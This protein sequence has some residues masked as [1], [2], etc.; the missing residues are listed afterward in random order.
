MRTEVLGYLSR[1]LRTPVNLV[2]FE[3]PGYSFSNLPTG[4][5]LIN[6]A[7]E[8]AY[9]QVCQAVPEDRVV[10]YG[11]SLGTGVMCRLAASHSPAGLILQS[12]YTSLASTA[13]P[14]SCA[15]LLPCCDMFESYGCAPLVKCPVQIIHGADD[16]IIPPR[17]SRELQKLFPNARP[18]VFVD[19][20]GHNNLLWALQD[21]PAGDRWVG[22][23][24]SFLASL[25]SAPAPSL[26]SFP[27]RRLSA[28]GAA[29]AD[30]S[31]VRDDGREPSGA[32]ASA[33]DGGEM[34]GTAQGFETPSGS[35]SG[36][37]SPFQTPAGERDGAGVT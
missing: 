14:T 17:C 19:G 4:E 2:A 13:V 6:A 36:S 16:S 35:G 37:R 30:A 20:A 8:A 15:R 18:A 34:L 5:A 31:R 25:G 10:L 7:A 28:L 26:V 22:I 9:T 3:Y 1:R 33:P 29:A 32:D 27:P 24:E 21:N 11:I 23:I 12:P